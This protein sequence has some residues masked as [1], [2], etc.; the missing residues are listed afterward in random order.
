MMAK[1]GLRHGAEPDAAFASGLELPYQLFELRPT[2]LRLNFGGPFHAPFPRRD[3]LQ[4]HLFLSPNFVL[5][6]GLRRRL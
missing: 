4:N 3:S 5:S 2:V 1:L 6:C